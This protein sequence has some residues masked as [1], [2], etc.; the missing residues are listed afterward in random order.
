MGPTP[1]PMRI[2]AGP[3]SPCAC[4]PRPAA[5]IIQR[6]PTPRYRLS[7]ILLVGT[8]ALFL[9][10][11]T[12]SRSHAQEQPEPYSVWTYSLYKTI[13]YE[14]FANLAD[15]PLYYTVLQGAAP[16]SVL[17]NTVNVLTAAAAYYT[18]E[19]GWNFYGPSIRN[20][21]ASVVVDVEIKKTL[22]YRVVSTARNLVL[23][24]AFTGSFTATVS[25]ALVSN[26]VD[27]AIYIANE[28]GWYAYGPTA[29]PGEVVP[30]PLL[31]SELG[32]S[33]PT[34]DDYRASA[35]AIGAVAGVVI[36]NVAT[37]GMATPVLALGAPGAISA[38]APSGAAYL[39]GLA[40]TAFGAFG[41]GY[42]VDWLYQQ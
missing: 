27:G 31:A 15:I 10:L 13:T 21:P 6:R 30:F 24:Y 2:L 33:A 38:V 5:C 8:A 7:K 3:A 16:T 19:V 42:V 25:F 35:I 4:V 39:A 29:V 22:L 36:A 37:G 34:E 28:Y 17:F 12:A 18:Y 20:Q 1:K 11:G 26:V 23:G 41:G 32:L 14:F 40:T 9:C